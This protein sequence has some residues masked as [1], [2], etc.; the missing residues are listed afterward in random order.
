[1]AEEQDETTER[2][3]EKALLGE[4]DEGGRISAARKVNARMH[5]R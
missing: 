5:D 2:A 1:M 3:G 4:E